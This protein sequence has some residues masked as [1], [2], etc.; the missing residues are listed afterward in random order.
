MLQTVPH[1]KS[2]SAHLLYAALIGLFVGLA[3]GFSFGL[4]YGFHLWGH[5]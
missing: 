1:P 2:P 5:G 3:A 4:L